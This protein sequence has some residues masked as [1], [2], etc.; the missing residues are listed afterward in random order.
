MPTG[1]VHLEGYRETMRSLE[2]IQHGAG[3]A[4]LGGLIEAAE[5][6]RA[7]WVR[8]LSRYRGASTSTISPKVVRKGV[9]VVQRKK[10]VTGRRPD[11]GT[12]EMRLGLFSLAE[13]APATL[14]A[15]EK[16]L[17]DLTENEGF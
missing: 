2:R 7:S 14:K 15:V 16:A 11:F 3:K 17:D 13:Q 5:P 8:K 9:L 1:T 4:V 12:L 10:K 6:V